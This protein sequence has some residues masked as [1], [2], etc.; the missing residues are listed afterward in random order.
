MIPTVVLLRILTAGDSLI[1]HKHGVIPK[2]PSLTPRRYRGSKEE[3]RM[4]PR[5][6]TPDPDG[7]SVL[8]DGKDERCVCPK[9]LRSFS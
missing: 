9:S 1:L 6:M 2:K 7:L 5:L 4:R 3:S 8:E